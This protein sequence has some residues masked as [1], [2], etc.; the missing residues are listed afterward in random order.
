MHTTK[1][2]DLLVREVITFGA[3]LVCLDTAA[4]LFGGN[5]NDRSQVR[6]FISLLADGLASPINGAVLLNC[7]PSRSGLASG[8]LDG[9]STAW[10]NTFR[11]RWSFARPDGDDVPADTPDRLLVR[12][13]ANYARIGDTIR[14]RWAN[15]VF[16]PQ[17][18]NGSGMSGFV[19]RAA[20]EAVFLTLLDRC[21]AAKQR[22]SDRNNASNYAP[23]AF[24]L[25][26]DAEGYTA[27]DFEE[28]MHGLFAR[29]QI[30]M[31]Q[32]G[33]PGDYRLRIVR[34][35]REEENC[36]RCGSAQST[37]GLQAQTAAAIR[38][39]EGL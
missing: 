32:Y 34:T 2:W 3:R 8:N 30:F 10:S 25:R 16:V 12:R 5:E 13:K 4:D 18:L 15:S 9:G 11:S 14:L 22:L 36:A 7:H 6:R 17:G 33:R 19:N 21:E 29:K 31:Q 35:P 20:A 26:P 39:G 37:A 24:A 38:R 1:R 23:K 28:A 27:K